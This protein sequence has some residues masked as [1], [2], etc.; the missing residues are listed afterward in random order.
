MLSNGKG[1]KKIN[2][3]NMISQKKRP[4]HTPQIAKA[5][6][7]RCRFVFLSDLYYLVEQYVPKHYLFPKH[8]E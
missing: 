4:I 1:R 2:Q 6:T 7:S 5:V 8:A 3:G